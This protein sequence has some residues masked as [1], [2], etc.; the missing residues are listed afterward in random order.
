MYLREALFYSLSAAATFLIR[1]D[2]HREQE[3]ISLRQKHRRCFVYRYTH[4]ETHLFIKLEAEE[5][6]LF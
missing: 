1:I 5:V 3:A 2:L 4:I 6:Y